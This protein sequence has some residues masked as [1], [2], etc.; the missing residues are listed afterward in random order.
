MIKFLFPATILF[1]VLLLPTISHAGISVADEL[2]GGYVFTVG[3]D[4]SYKNTFFMYSPKTW[5]L[6]EEFGGVSFVKDFAD[7]EIN[8][9]LVVQ[10]V[11]T[12]HKYYDKNLFPSK[13]K[14]KSWFVKNYISKMGIPATAQNIIHKKVSIDGAKGEYYRYDEGGIT[15]VQVI[16]TKFDK[17]YLI[18]SYI[19]TSKWK[20]YETSIHQ[21]IGSLSIRKLGL[22][23]K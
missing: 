13:G 16:F 10:E 1:T 23:L 9:E 21:S 8:A 12:D 19:E 20:Q 5:S 7:S 11:S 14:S 15:F 18:H 2:D 4:G 6:P 22:E 3:L 17:V